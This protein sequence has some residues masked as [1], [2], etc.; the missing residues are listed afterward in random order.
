MWCVARVTCLVIIIV[1]ITVIIIIMKAFI[2]PPCIRVIKPVQRRYTKIN[3]IP[4]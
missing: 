2:K 1:A 4:E 3:V